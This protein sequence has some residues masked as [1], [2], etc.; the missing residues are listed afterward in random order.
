M[1]FDGKGVSCFRCGIR[2][3]EGRRKQFAKEG[4]K[5]VVWI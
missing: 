5:V 1:R 4:G 3:R 2:H